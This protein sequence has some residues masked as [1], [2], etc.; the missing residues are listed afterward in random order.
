MS[1]YTF[2]NTMFTFVCALFCI[3][4]GV[5]FLTMTDGNKWAAAWGISCIAVGVVGFGITLYIFF[6]AR[7]Y[8]DHKEHVDTP[9]PPRTLPDGRKA[10]TVSGNHWGDIFALPC[11]LEISKRKDEDG[12]DRSFATLD[13]RQCVWW[14]DKCC[15]PYPTD[16]CDQA[17]RGDSIIEYN[18]GRWAIVHTAYRQ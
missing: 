16:N 17:R 1:K 2:Y 13:C 12:G 4:L 15:N 6:D 7:S 5:C 3:L 11:I 9:P 14:N 18:N 10:I 8:Y